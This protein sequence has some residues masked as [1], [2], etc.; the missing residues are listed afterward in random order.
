[1]T[2]VANWKP[3]KGT[4]ARLKAKRKRHESQ[5]KK[6]VREQTVERDGDCLIASRLLA[7]LRTLLGP[8][9][10]P[11]EWAHIGTHRRARTRGQA[12]ERRHTTAGSGM[13]CQKH[14]QAYD[15][16]QFDFITDT[17][18]MDGMIGIVRRAA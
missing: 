18:G 10:G 5:V 9:D 6:S 17:A 13:L 14:H 2:H 11:S 12:A 4:H 3:A 8:C 7:P 1:M 15:A 16:Y